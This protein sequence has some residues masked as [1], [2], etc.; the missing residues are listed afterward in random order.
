MRGEREPG[1]VTMGNLMVGVMEGV[2]V[3]LFLLF[4]HIV[5]YCWVQRHATH[6]IA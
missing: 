1:C 4:Q 6:E 2:R 3:V 5:I